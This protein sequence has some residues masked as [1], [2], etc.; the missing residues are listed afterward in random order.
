MVKK[1][2]LSL[3]LAAIAFTAQA[4]TPIFHEGFDADQTKAATELGWYEFIN[5][6]EGDT[7]VIVSEGQ[8]AGA[9]CLQIFNSETSLCENQGWQRAIKFRNLPLE[10]GKIY[11]INFKFK[12]SN[13]Y[14]KNGET[15]DPADEAN[16]PR[17]EMRVG[18][19]QG[20]ENTDISILDQNGADQT[21]SQSYF[22]PEAY[23]SYS[24]NFYFADKA[25]QDA[26][27]KA[28]GK[29]EAYINN[30]FATLNI[31]NPGTFY[32]DEVELVAL[33]GAVDQ[34][35]Y[36]GDVIRV[37]YMF[38]TNIAALAGADAL[39]RVILDRSCASVK[40][41]GETTPVE[42][43]ELHK[44][45]YLYI[46]LEEQYIESETSV[47][48]SFTNPDDVINFSGTA[49]DAKVFAFE[50]VTA[51]GYDEEVANVSSFAYEEAALVSS[52]PANNSFCLD[53]T[54]S[55]FTFTFDHNIFTGENEFANAPKAVLST[56]EALSIKEGQDEVSKSI[57]FVRTSTAPLSKGAYTLTVSEITTEKGTT[58][59]EDIVLSFETGKI[60][61]A[62]T[63]YTDVFT[64]LLTGANNGQPDG[65]TILVGG[66]NWNG[67][68]PK[69]N[70]GSACRNIN[71][72]KDG[73]EYT[74]FYLCDRDGY[75]YMKYGDQEGYTLTLPV[76]NIAFSV[77]AVGHENAGR[78][79]DY[80]IE[81]LDGNVI[82]SCSEMTDVLA[83]NN[84]S[85]MSEVTVR[86]KNDKEQNV[87]VK[88]HEPEGG[89]TACRIMGLKCQT[90]VE[91]EG[92]KFEP[93]VILEGKF[94]DANMPAE[95]SGWLFYEN[96]NQ[97]TPGSGRSGTSGML[98]NNFHSK[99]GIAAFFRECGANESAAMRIEYANGNGIEGGIEIPEGNYE[100]TYYAGTWNDDGG[101]AAGT[102]KVFMQLIDAETGA[103]AFNSEHVNIANF[104][105]GGNC[106]G[107]AD[108]VTA[109]FNCKGGKYYLKAWGTSNTVWGALS[110]VKPGSQ[111]VKYYAALAEAVAEAE[112]EAE[113]SA[114]EK[115]NGTTKT[116]LLA[117]IAKGKDPS[118]M[119]T[120]EEFT[121][122]IEKLGEL[123]DAMAAR[124]TN[125]NSFE[126]N[127]N[128]IATALTNAEGTKYENLEVYPKAVECYNTYKEVNPT[129]LDD[130]TLA[131]AVADMGNM[132]QLINNMTNTCVGLLTKQAVSL[133]SMIV[134]LDSKESGNS[135]VIA[136]GEAISDDQELVANLKKVYT[137]KLYR[138]IADGENPFEEYDEEMEVTS[139]VTIN[140]SAM[141]QNAEFYSTTIVPAGE[142]TATSAVTDYP[143]WTIDL[144]KGTIRPVWNTGWG[145]A[146]PTPVKPIENCAVRTGWGDAEYDVKQVITLPVATYNVS[147]LIGK[148]GAQSTDSYVYVG[149]GDAQLTSVY[150]GE[151]RD[152]SVPQSFEGVAPVINGNF[153]EITLGAHINIAGSFANVDN[154]VLEMVGPAAGFAYADAAKALEEEVATTIKSVATP[155]GEPVMVQYYNVGGAQVAKPAPGSVVIKAAVYKNG[156]MVISKFIAK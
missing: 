51:N 142:V 39:G 46:F 50:A 119:H 149:E 103:I 3:G 154:A 58:C 144:I 53:E 29:D 88:I 150:T 140:A 70:N 101:N 55:E 133:A 83:E 120:V 42:A 113:L 60:Q 143:G 45:G 57:T 121:A 25:N 147:L 135:Y 108:K 31:I 71:L 125:F 2:L 66:S 136:V 20:Y 49:G 67:G 41:G 122:A 30:Y 1:T 99:M 43:V 89:Y 33:P 128:T 100:V 68:D 146:A 62:Q 73:V 59:T 69:E 102:S 11:Q 4:Q 141:V 110:I 138:K 35:T 104:K 85:K 134:D 52:N 156:A 91:T 152:E 130:A 24:Y 64:T 79:V 105:N 8:A 9:G 27:Y 148:D 81:D 10:S 74:A 93:E 98:S 5:S 124:R 80:Q 76:G 112:A 48:V 63:I 145:Q 114:D 40:V 131:S 115:Y 87:I 19:M 107:Q 32:I 13:R 92:D 111:A 23:E 16:N 94:T 129:D 132:G 38:N 90:Y 61:M 65:W 22:N 109:T 37:K 77:L 82:A 155:E 18:L 153:G 12:G 96:N 86:F 78:R 36:G 97:L 118:D 14:N 7:R 106:N 17:C 116:A 123:K 34:I 84:F 95:G 127:R 56:G 47:E 6:Q 72:T 26:Q 54:I 151:T 15:V 28:Q 117:E 75:T 137:A 21:K 44:D 126:G 139:P